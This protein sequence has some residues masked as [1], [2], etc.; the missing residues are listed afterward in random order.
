MYSGSVLSLSEFYHMGLCASYLLE[1]NR[2]IFFK[3]EKRQL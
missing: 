2:E 1:L 3:Y